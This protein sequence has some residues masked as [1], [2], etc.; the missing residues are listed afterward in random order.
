MVEDEG[1]IARGL[2]TYDWLDG[3][4]IGRYTIPHSELNEPDNVS[5]SP[6][7]DYALAQFEFCERGM[8]GTYEAPCGPMIYTR[9]LSSGWGLLR[10]AGHGDMAVDA[11]GREVLVYQD[12]DNDWI[13]M[14]DLET[15]AVTPLLPLDF[16]TGIFGLHISGRALER[17]G[18]AAVSVQ[19]E[20]PTLDFNNPFWM[21]GTVFAVELKANPRVI[22]LAHHHS[23]RSDAESDYFA[24]PQVTVNR[25]FTRLLFTSNWGVYG[26]GEVDMYL[27]MLPDNWFAPPAVR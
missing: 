4:I 8:V 14:V 16:S 7:G 5:M 11:S 19:P 27:I 6:L 21:V 9:D 13:S 18:W 15:S 25:D 3:R 24:E 1:F 2:I 17:A 20:A 12:V 22:Q 10:I 26:K 23:I